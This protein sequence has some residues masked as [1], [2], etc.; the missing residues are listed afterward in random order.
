MKIFPR[1]HRQPYKPGDF[2][3]ADRP[4]A[5]LD[6]VTRRSLFGLAQGTFIIRPDAHYR[7]RRTPA[8]GCQ[9]EYSL[10]G[11]SSAQSGRSSS[12]K[13]VTHEIDRRRKVLNSAILI[14]Q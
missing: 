12:S 1:T 11:T 8:F 2:I 6:A 14:H 3:V 4:P 5:N 9:E 7:I 10:A 13:S